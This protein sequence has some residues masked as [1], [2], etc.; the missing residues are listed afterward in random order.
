LNAHADTSTLNTLP[1]TVVA[2]TD[3]DTP[4]H[5][6]VQLRLANDGPL[7]LARITVRS[8]RALSIDTGLPVIAQLKSVAILR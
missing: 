4:G 1:A 8:C 2:V 5:A 7:L 6:L 3:A